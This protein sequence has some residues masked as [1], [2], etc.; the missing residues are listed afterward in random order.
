MGVVS[1]LM[2]KVLPWSERTL[3]VF[4]G[5]GPLTL[6]HHLLLNLEVKKNLINTVKDEVEKVVKD[7]SQDG[8]PRIRR[9]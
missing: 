4:G 6:T 2:S 5:K 9:Y 1:G 3:G 8:G 7:V